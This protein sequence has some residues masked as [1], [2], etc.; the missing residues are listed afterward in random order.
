[1][2][3]IARITIGTPMNHRGNEAII[4]ETN[5]QVK[6]NKVNGKFLFLTMKMPVEFCA[7]EHI[8]DV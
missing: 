7:Q 8:F 5:S 1:M 2:L 4:A 6:P 3:I